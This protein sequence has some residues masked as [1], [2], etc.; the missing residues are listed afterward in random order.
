MKINKERKQ[1][2]RAWGWVDLLLKVCSG[3]A[4]LICFG[5]R[6]KESRRNDPHK[7]LG[8]EHSRNPEHSMKRTMI[9]KETDVYG[10]E[11]R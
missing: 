10:T 1:N 5:L 3:K 6:K 8:K 7:C 9:R 11:R 2:R 4:S